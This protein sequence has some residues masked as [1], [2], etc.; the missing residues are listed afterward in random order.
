M[1]KPIAR[2]R[3][4]NRRPPAKSTVRSGGKHRG[5]GRPAAG[6]Q[7]VGREALITRTCEMLMMM[8]PNKITRAEVA[9]HMNVDPSLIRYY[10]R[11]RSTL[12]LA[13]VARLTAELSR[14]MDEELAR[15]DLTPESRLRARVS[16]LLKLNVTYP[17]FHRLMID[18]LVTLDTPAAVRFVE[19]L[20]RD[21][22]AGYTEVID[23]GVKDGV[24]RRTSVP[25]LFLAVIGMCEFF[26][27]GMPILRIVMG[28]DFD[29]RA[30]SAR[31][32]EFICELLL[33]GLKTR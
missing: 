29:Q 3:T 27:N 28:K 1:P 33:D 30:I 5:I 26:V 16:A 8:P 19:Q 20:T 14:L 10:F 32:R 13:A 9:R 31:Y 18:E 6:Q 11:D 7:T 2:Q 25:F 23:A 22:V 4:A 17:F 21:G 12:L 24:F 15:S